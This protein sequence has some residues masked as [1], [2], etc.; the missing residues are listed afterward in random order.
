MFETDPHPGGPGV[1]PQLETE[2]LRLRRLVPDGLDAYAAMYA[3]AEVTRCLRDCPSIEWQPGIR[4]PVHLGHW[5]LHG[6]G[7]WAVVER[8]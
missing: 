1:I 8:A 4:W 2:R 5:E 6:Y 7:Q 3:A